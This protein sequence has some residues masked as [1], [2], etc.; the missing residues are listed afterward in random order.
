M[1]F[2][3]ISDNYINIIFNITITYVENNC[4]Y[5]IKNTLWP[6]VTFYFKLIWF[7]RV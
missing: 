3:E 2:S 5:L 1:L 7:S 6:N 4:Y